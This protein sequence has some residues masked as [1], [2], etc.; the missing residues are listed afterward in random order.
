MLMVFLSLIKYSYHSPIRSITCL[1]LKANFSMA[2][3]NLIFTAA[4][5]VDF[6]RQEIS[7]ESYI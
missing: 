6:L 4:P 5:K 2:Y 3:L 7:T 1:Y